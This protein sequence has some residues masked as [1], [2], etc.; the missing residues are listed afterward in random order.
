ME[1]AWLPWN[2]LRQLGVMGLNERNADFILPYN[3][4]R[5]FPLVDNKL[6]TKSLALEAGIAVP[7]LFGV[8]EMVHQ[9]ERLE[10]LLAPHD[11]FVIKPAHGAGGEG[12]L[13]ITGR[14]RGH[15]RKANGVLSDEEDVGHHVSN[16][17]GGLYSL[18]GRPDKAL[19][20][21]RVKFDP[22]FENISFQG[23]PDIRILV[24][25]GIPVM[26]MIRLPTRL[27]D[28]KANLHQGAIGV[29]IDLASGRTFSGVWHDRPIDQHPDTGGNLSGRL[30]PY[31]D[32]IL[33]MTAQCQDFAGLGFIGV[34]IVL[35]A[36]FGPMMLEMNARPGL[37]IQL[38]NQLGLQPRLR[39]V[40]E[41]ASVP[42][43]ISERVQAAKNLARYTASKP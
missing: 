33:A 23:V 42:E 2:R 18:G 21:Y 40:K 38:A 22:I 12:I 24:F 35:D 13:V 19:I 11:D 10:E 31:W 5:N 36:H 43:A 16:I 25:R 8:V 4:R 6:L 32:E 41:M 29:G 34:D 7:E 27:S 37:T 14:H 3:G 28:G 9:I 20:E 39:H 15:Y 30:I 26:A 17:L 1:R